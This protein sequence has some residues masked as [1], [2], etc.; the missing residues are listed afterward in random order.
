[1]EKHEL[2]FTKMILENKSRLDTQEITNEKLILQS[3]RKDI[4]FIRN[5]TWSSRLAG[6]LATSYATAD[7]T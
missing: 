2:E 6:L 5:K 7:L 3:I 4:S 1:M